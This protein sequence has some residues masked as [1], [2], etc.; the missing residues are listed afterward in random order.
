[1]RINF[2]DGNFQVNSLESPKEVGKILY[3]FLVWN[4]E[5][6]L[7]EKIDS[8]VV[9]DS[10]HQA[11]ELANAEYLKQDWDGGFGKDVPYRNHHLS[12]QEKIVKEKE[13]NFQCHKAILDFFVSKIMEKI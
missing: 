10:Y 6:A 13:E 5:T 8:K 7:K 3:E 4:Y 11:N 1:M 9:L 2:N 12:Q